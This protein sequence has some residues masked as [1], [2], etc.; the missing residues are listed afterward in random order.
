MSTLHR[1]RIS[2][3]AL[4]IPHFLHEGA[5][6]P[7][8]YVKMD[9]ICMSHSRNPY[10]WLLLN[11]SA[12]KSKNTL[13]SWLAHRYQLVIRD[14]GNL[15][16]KA[17]FNF[18]YAKLISL[19]TLAL[20]VLLM[21]SLALTTTILNKWLNPAYVE[22]EN[23]KK[24]IQLAQAVDVLEEQT[25]QQQQFIELLQRIIAGKEPP[26]SELRTSDKE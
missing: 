15:A 16:E 2:T 5:L 13:S 14:G 6:S 21:C 7:L 20:S 19:G 17:T 1:S 11:S 9:H 26:A 10:L 8:T 24:L 22:Q 23:K 4:A 18:S 12:L 25:A 3:T